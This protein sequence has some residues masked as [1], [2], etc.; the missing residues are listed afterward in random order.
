MCWKNEMTE[1]VVG[2]RVLEFQGFRVS[3]F[4]AWGIS[5]TSG[6][7]GGG[8]GGGENLDTPEP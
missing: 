1:E 3:G 6:G 4:G 2:F 8:G 7:G 5:R